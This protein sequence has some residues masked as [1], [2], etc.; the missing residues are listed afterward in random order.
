MYLS[1]RGIFTDTHARIRQP[2]VIL[3][4]LESCKHMLQPLLA[5]HKLDAIAAVAKLLLEDK[6]FESPQLAREAYPSVFAA[7]GA[8]RQA[9]E[10][11]TTRSETAAVNCAVIED[12]SESSANKERNATE[13]N[14]KIKN[15]KSY[16]Y[17]G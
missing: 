12:E 5:K 4:R 17:N 2:K 16:E 14:G 9:L 7:P 15:L 10:A 11:E 6:I 8:E 3:R 1:C 13:D